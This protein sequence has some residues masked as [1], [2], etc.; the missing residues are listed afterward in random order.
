VADE[1][2]ERLRIEAAFVET[3]Q[4]CARLRE[5]SSRDLIIESIGRRFGHELSLRRQT[6]VRLSILELVRV[7]AELPAGLEILTAEVEFV[8]PLAPQLPELHHLCDEHVAE[9]LLPDVWTELRAALLPMS[10]SARDWVALR[11]FAAASIG[12]RPDA[13]PPHC[14]TV[15]RTF[16]YLVRTNHDAD[17]SPPAVA[18]LD[19]VARPAGA[20]GEALTGRL[21]DS[22]A[23]GH[24]DL[25]T[26]VEAL[27]QVPCMRT[28]DTR[29]LL[30]AQLGSPIA[31]AVTYHRQRR[32][33]A[34]NIIVACRDHD[35]GL[36][37]LIAAIRLVDG[38]DSR[39]LRRLVSIVEN[40]P[41]NFSG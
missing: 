2:R 38:A 3:L 39:P 11:E 8:D 36:A 37:R 35:G 6:T 14:S 20:A 21:Q 4:R 10:V 13:L 22:L 17:G 33:L 29:E 41:Q 5:D 19:R 34:L 28:E 40:L 31:G 24:D 18:F 32:A 26:L 12:T 27:E 25:S 23:P 15:W 16:V 7:C 1:H 9:R 30:V